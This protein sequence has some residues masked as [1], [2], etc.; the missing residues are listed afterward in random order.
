MPAKE[1]FTV[2][3]VAIILGTSPAAIRM[4]VSRGQE[5][6]S[7]P[8]SIKLGSKR[9]WLRRAVY[10][11]LNQKAV[12]RSSQKPSNGR[13]RPRRRATGKLRSD[14]NPKPRR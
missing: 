12:P 11:W 6:D 9:R 1:V 10:A 2:D 4:A 7:I 3:E 13:G 14:L 5:G 8:P